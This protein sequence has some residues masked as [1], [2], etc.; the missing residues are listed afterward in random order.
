M[1]LTMSIAVVEGLSGTQV[2]D[3]LDAELT[4]E[5]VSF[6]AAV[7]AVSTQSR[8]RTVVLDDPYDDAPALEDEHV[9]ARLSRV[10]SVALFQVNE[11]LGCGLYMAGC[12]AEGVMAWKVTH[13]REEPETEEFQ[14]VG[15]PPVGFAAIAGSYRARQAQADAAADATGDYICHLGGAVVDL[16]ALVTGIEFYSPSPGWWDKLAYS[17]LRPRNEG[18]GN[19]QV[20][21]ISDPT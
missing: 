13:C 8:Y 20:W 1:A 5:T 9:L 18:R 11:H 6:Y 17:V 14:V 16:F 4:G 15:V 3:R 21:G 10:A 12:W 7:P 2:A 19:G